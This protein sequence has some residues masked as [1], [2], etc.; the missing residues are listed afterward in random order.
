MH[1]PNDVELA[2]KRLARGV[3][4]HCAEQGDQTGEALYLAGASTSREA[5]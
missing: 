5:T 4:L 3:T 2:M 1:Q